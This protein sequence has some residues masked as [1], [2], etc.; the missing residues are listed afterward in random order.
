MLEILT[1]TWAKIIGRPQADFSDKLVLVIDDND[2][3]RKLVEKTV[4]RLGCGVRNAKDGR[5]GLDIILARK[6]D[7]VILDC[8]MP[9]MSGWEMCQQMRQLND[10]KDIPVIFLTSMNTPKNILECFELDAEN[11]LSKPVNAQVLVN[12]VRTILTSS[13]PK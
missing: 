13:Q 7:L 3:D 2:V 9:V 1:Q 5:E 12:N 11:F 10:I 4:A 8:D 6:P